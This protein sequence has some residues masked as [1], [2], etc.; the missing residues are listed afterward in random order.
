MIWGLTSKP[1]TY[2]DNYLETN[3]TK[4]EPETHE[5][6]V[7]KPTRIY[8]EIQNEYEHQMVS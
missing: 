5:Q 7:S 1:K 8:K 3:G 2:T 4:L 6:R